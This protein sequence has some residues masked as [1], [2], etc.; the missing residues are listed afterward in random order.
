MDFYDNLTSDGVFFFWIAIVLALS[1]VGLAVFLL[2]R[3][4]KLASLLKEE[5]TVVAYPVDNN[6]KVEISEADAPVKTIEEKV[7]P[8]ILQIENKKED[9]VL[10]IENKNNSLPV[11]NNEVIQNVEVKPHVDNRFKVSDDIPKLFEPSKDIEKDKGSNS[12]SKPYQKNVLREISKKMPI[13]PIHIER[14]EIDDDNDIYT[15][16]SDIDDTY[17]LEGID[18]GENNVSPLEEMEDTYEANDNMKEI[19]SRMEEE[20]KPSNIE[21][22]DYEKKQE[23]EAIISYDELQ[24]VKDKI[25]N[26]TEEEEDGEFIDELKNFRLDLK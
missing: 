1:L 26:L 21:L 11:K 14:D 24:K 4:R 2:L 8:E 10:Q 18:Y 13:S 22:T 5:K 16:S 19:V 6:E 25:Y 17:D 23:E 20:V 9:E 7:E 3:N 12:D 15:V